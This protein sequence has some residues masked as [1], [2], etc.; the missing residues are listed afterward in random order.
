MGRRP[1]HAGRGSD[2]AQAVRAKHSPRHRA[3]QGRRV[4]SPLD[5]RLS[6]VSEH[7][8]NL[9]RKAPHVKPVYTVIDNDKSAPPG[10]AGVRIAPSWRSAGPDRAVGQLS[11]RRRDKPMPASPRL[12]RAKVPGSGTT[13]AL[14]E[15]LS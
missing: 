1:A 12:R 5:K 6:Q 7:A 14:N 9:V 3:L 8:R 13:P 15:K 10:V 11:V 2:A 4:D